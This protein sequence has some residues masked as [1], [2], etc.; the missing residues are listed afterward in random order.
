MSLLTRYFS[1]AAGPGD[2]SGDSWNNRAALFSAGVLSTVIT[3]HNFGGTDG[4]LC[5]IGPG[6]YTQSTQI[7][8]ASFTTAV[9]TAANPLFL[10]GCDSS[11]AALSPPDP[12][13]TA[14][15]AAWTDT[16][17]PVIA[18]T[19]NIAHLNFSTPSNVFCRLL[20]FTATARTSA[21]MIVAVPTDWCVLSSSASATTA[22]AITNPVAYNSV[23]SMTGNQYAAAIVMGG[24]ELL[25]NCKLIGVTGTDP[26][27]NNGVNNAVT[28]HAEI[29][30]CCISGFGGNG[31]AGTS[32]NVAQGFRALYNVIAN[33]GGSGIKPNSTA[34]QTIQ[35]V[36]MHNMITGNGAYGIDFNTNARIVAL[37]NRLRDNATAN[38]N[39]LGN[40]PT[41]LNYTTD[42]SD[43]D[44]Y[45]AAGSNDFRIKLGATIHGQ[46]YG[47]VDQAGGFNSGGSFG[48]FP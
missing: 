39:G 45:V 41:T 17:L 26:T 47:V 32:P 34:S 18:T 12:N 14:A 33:N 4:M 21:S 10:H 19:T 28:N 31:I 5:L 22:S 11:G 46:G 36:I 16:T 15:E 8:A 6:N 44:E 27:R 13:W 29:I 43:A 1:T 30:R 3:G 37:A 38:F 24:S 23:I 25:Y 7:A 20:K 35:H 48:S 40:Y 9:P 42:S 2:G